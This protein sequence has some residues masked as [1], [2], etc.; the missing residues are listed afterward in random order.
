[1][2]AGTGSFSNTD[3]R[4]MHV[5]PIRRPRGAVLFLAAAALGAAIIGSMAPARGQASAEEETARLV[6]GILKRYHLA[7]PAIDDEVSKKWFANYIK[8]LDPQKYYFEKADVEAFTAKASTLD[9]TVEKGDI[10]FA[11]EVFE[12]FRKRSDERFDVVMKLLDEKPDFTVDESLIDDPEHTSYPADAAEANE[13]WRKRIKLD[14]LYLKVDGVDREEAVK[15]LKIRYR[16]RNRNIHQLDTTD[17]LEIY[18]TS[19]ATTL[20]AHTSYM[21]PKTVEDLKQALRLSLEGIGASLGSEDGYAVVKE[22]V[23]GGAADR[24]G[25]LQVED[26]IVALQK[27][28]GS[29][30]D[31]VEKKL[32]DVVRQI[33]GPKGSKIRLVVQPNDSKE[34]K[35]YELVRDKIQLLDQ[36]A[37]SQIVTTK[38]EGNDTP[39]KIGVIQFP[40]FYGNDDDDGNVSATADC[41]K[42]LETFEEQKVDAV[43]IDLRGN[44]GGLL[45]E[46]ISLSGLFIRKGPVVQVRD[47]KGVQPPLNDRDESV[48]YSGPLAVLIDHQSASASEI[49]AGVIRDY[50]RGLIIGDSSTYG[51]GTVQKIFDLNDIAPRGM[52]DI[53][54]LKL[55]IQQFYR[56]NG[57]STQIKGVPPHVHIPSLL[58]QYDIGEGKSE[59]ALKFDRIKPLEHD[60][61]DRT[62][63]KIVAEI[64][65]RSEARRKESAKFRKQAE[66]IKKVIARK[67]KKA[68]SLSEEKFRAE[69]VPPEDD[70][71]GDTKKDEAKGKPKRRQ[72]DRAAWEPGF[73]NDEVLAIIADYV[74]LGAKELAAKR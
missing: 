24:D 37:K 8:A 28:D 20:D 58:D 7:H 49:F 11:K 23:P 33:R 15:R 35:V 74:S 42:F 3:A 22:I 12:K 30:I 5:F 29:E 61:F 48:A 17:L 67:E 43:L 62:P 51:K 2:S 64:N 4:N 26:K 31:L 18:L 68:I 6:V 9:D 54:A 34:R 40:S 44:G 71:N 59:A 52:P 1:M 60:E 19:L 41:K 65:E 55:T 47:Y 36:H 56:A 50:G 13:R 72:T 10:S 39:I 57:E 69:Y 73:Y 21:G 38:A 70:E 66:L 14:L 53:G 45:G 63:S 32:S 46:A 25:R 16:D 27:D